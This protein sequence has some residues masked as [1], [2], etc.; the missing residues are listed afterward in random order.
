MNRIIHTCAVGIAGVFGLLSFNSQP[1]AAMLWGVNGHPLVSYPG[2]TI[3]E[4]LMLLGDLGAKSYRV[5]VTGLD[6]SAQLGALIA[7][8][9]RRN[10]VVLP[11]LIPP[12]SLSKETVEELYRKSFD[13]ARSLV[14]QFGRDVPV[15]ELGNELENF[16][17]IQPCE[18]R[19][20]GTQYPCEWGPAGGWSSL[21]YFGP[22]YLKVAAVLRGLSEGAHAADPQAVRAIGSAGWGHVGIF[23]RLHRDGI[24]WEISVW[25]HYDGDPEP[26]FEALATFG[27]PIWVTEFN[28][29][30]G[31]G[32]DG[33]EGQAAGLHCK[34]RRY[35]DL[36]Q[37]YRVEAAF[38]YELLDE[39]YWPPGAETSM[40]L[41]RLTK[42]GQGHWAL[43]GPKAAY[44]AA[45][46]VI[47]DEKRQ[48]SSVCKN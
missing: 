7:A 21:E 44:A 33:E 28:H 25:H 38:I 13:F 41:I 31:S 36:A 6:K 14:Q 37:K 47:A 11:V 19:D 48:L 42:T 1:H 32:R 45:R 17:I 26:A 16:A 34:M 27:R 23:E 2:V 9:K 15:W 18:R 35:I 39:T 29:N 5:D 12:V 4:Q 22:R 46:R 30:L 43:G 10:M 24:A 20:D 40:G 8:A 3:E